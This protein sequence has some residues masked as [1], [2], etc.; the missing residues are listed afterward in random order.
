MAGLCEGGNEPAGSL[1]AICGFDGTSNVL[2]GKLYNIPV[3]GTHAHA[4]VT[5]FS[6]L[7]EL[8]TKVLAHRTTGVRHD[9]LELC[10][11]WREE[12]APLLSLP[13][14]EASDGELAAWISFAIAFP[15]GFMALVDTYDVRRWALITK[16]V[17]LVEMFKVIEH[18]TDCE[19]LS[20]IRF[21]NA[22]NIKPADIHRQ[23]CEVYGDDAISDRMVRRWVR[24]FNKDRVS[25]HD[26]QR[27][28]R[29]SLIKD[30]LVRAVDE[31]IHEDRRSIT[32]SKIVLMMVPKVLTEEHKTKRASSALSFFTRYSEQGDEFLDHIVTGDETWVSHMTPES[33]QQAME[34]RHTA[35]PRKK[36]FKQTMS[37]RK[38]M[39]TVFLDRKGV[40]LIEFLPRGETINRENYCQTLK[41]LRHAI[42]NKRRGM[43]TDGVV[44]LHD[45]TRPHT[46][47][48]TQ[49]L[50]SKF[51]W[52][53]IDHPPYSPDLAPSD[54]HLFLH[55]KKFLSGQRFDGDDE[56]KTAVRSGSHCRRVN[57]TMR[58]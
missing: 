40:L 19:M 55:L 29:P 3:N 16:L 18:P 14:S 31:K 42:Q 8:K 6:D 2:A 12:L 49:N 45:N 58:G 22:R 25:V 34:W 43:L 56:V 47:R 15:S 51:G 50:I 30:D 44:L 48:D 21:L 57:S 11:K 33:K 37:T 13:A 54:F 46:A 41:K 38:I 39:C 10:T 7:K 52:E 28:G 1:K 9:M 5:S 4:Y 53:Q 27:T 36:K 20:V 35:L 23:L 32:I 24:K 26:E 17:S